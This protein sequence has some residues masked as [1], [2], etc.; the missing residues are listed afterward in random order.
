MKENVIFDYLPPHLRSIPQ[1]LMLK[2]NIGDKKLRDDNQQI[3]ELAREENGGIP[4]VLVLKIVSENSKHVFSFRVS[5]F[6]YSSSRSF[7]QKFH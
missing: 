5:I 3:Q 2:K 4:I 1:K 7:P 6:N